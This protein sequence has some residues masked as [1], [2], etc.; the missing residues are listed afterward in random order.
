MHPFPSMSDY[1]HHFYTEDVDD[2]NVTQDCGVR[3]KFDQ[4]SCVNHYDQSL[5]GG[6]LCYV[7]NIQEII[8]VDFS[9]F[10][11]VIFRCKLWDTFNRNNVKEYCDSGLICINSRNMWEKVRIVRLSQNIATKYYFT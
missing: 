6:M 7:K 11:C 9:Y 10:Q 8:Q 2:G 3:V 5:I 4:S 1:G